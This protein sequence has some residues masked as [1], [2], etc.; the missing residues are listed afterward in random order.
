MPFR[1]MLASTRAPLPLRGEWVLE[2]KFDGWRA[3]VA[4]DDVVR[5]WTRTGHELTDKLPEFAPLGD[6]LAGGSVVL[7][8]ELVAWRPAQRVGA[9]ANGQQLVVADLQVR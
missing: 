9:Y 7:D 8:G 6:M 3:I 1:P 5:V 4:V 2:P